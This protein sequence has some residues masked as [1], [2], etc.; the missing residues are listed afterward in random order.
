MKPFQIYGTDLPPNLLLIAKILLLG[1]LLK[2]YHNNLP[3][4][5]AP[6][7]PI[8]E[9]I[10]APYWRRLLKLVVFLGGISLVFNHSVRI[11]C[12]AI[13]AVFIVATMSARTEFHNG[14]F[15][16]GLVFV[17]IGL[18]ERGKPPTLLAWQLGVMYF[19]A[20]LNKLLEADWRSGQ[21]F[22]NFL[23]TVKQSPIYLTAAGQLPDG[24]LPL[25]LCWQVITMEIS[26]G[27]L[28]FVPRFRKIAVWLAAGVHAGAAVLVY[29]D[30]GIY[31]SA[32][33]TSYLLVLEW[34]DRLAVAA[35]RAGLGAILVFLHRLSHR[36]DPTV[37]YETRPSTDLE[38]RVDER[39]HTG[40]AAF[41]RLALW[42]PALY[43]FVMIVMTSARGFALTLA[44]L[45]LGVAAILAMI[46]AAIFWLQQRRRAIIP[47]EAV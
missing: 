2:G 17:M 34:P 40:F 4:V 15:F 47:A 32:V 16:L 5:F 42:T 37:T 10:P 44:V 41:W 12:F 30:Y 36:N 46:V 31:L 24:L 27:I 1:L 25:L 7:V 9:G 45:G 22:A 26:A 6:I 8:F 20:G 35:P 3:D 21:Y 23:G 11:S 13:G 43:A 38:I 14:T 28:F 39:V 19:G 29:A 18:Q 33:L